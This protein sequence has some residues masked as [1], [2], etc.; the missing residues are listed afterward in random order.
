M[1]N[2]CVTNTHS[3]LILYRSFAF[4][5]RYILTYTDS[6]IDM[7]CIIIFSTAYTKINIYSSDV[8]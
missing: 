5:Y 3:F 7:K 4:V 1:P 2:S 8:H 6:I